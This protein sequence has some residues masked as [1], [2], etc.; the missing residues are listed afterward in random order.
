MSEGGEDRDLLAAEYVLGV[1]TPEQARA[2]EALA[3]HDPVVADSVVAWQN[4]LA[5]LAAVV[6]P[7]AP[8]PLLWR[9]L[10]LAAGIATEP[11]AMPM[12]M[13]AR[14]AVW[15]GVAAA[16]LAVAAC[17][18]FLLLRPASPELVAVLSPAGAPGPGFVVRVAADGHAVVR[19]VQAKPPPGASFELWA[20]AENTTV[21]VSLGLLPSD[22]QRE[23]TIANRA[24]T[25]LLVSQEPQGGSPTGLPTGPVVFSGTLAGG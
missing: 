18:G 19:T 24:G 25:K 7:Q 2:L 11:A 14:V 17:L 10:A 3:L 4:R 23:L 12:P 6:P 1:L 9:R 21:P 16:A 8:P 20:L 22:G 15:R 5:P 13:L